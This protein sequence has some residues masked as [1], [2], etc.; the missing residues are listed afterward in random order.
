METLHKH[1]TT[2]M[3]SLSLVSTLKR[4]NRDCAYLSSY[5]QYPVSSNTRSMSSSKTSH[6]DLKTKM[7]QTVVQ[8]TQEVVRGMVGLD[9]HGCDRKFDRVYEMVLTIYNEHKMLLD[10]SVST[11]NVTDM[12]TTVQSF[13]KVHCS[14]N[15]IC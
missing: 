7:D 3:L 12:E 8:I 11:L 10:H 1:D 14:A 13:A 2:T 4:E 5:Y 9:A 15:Y 6:F